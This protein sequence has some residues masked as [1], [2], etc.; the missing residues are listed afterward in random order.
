[1]VGSKTE[2][3]LVGQRA[4]LKPTRYTGAYAI[5][6]RHNPYFKGNCSFQEKWGHCTAHKKLISKNRWHHFDDNHVSSK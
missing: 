4:V 6:R 1:M 3:A 2:T 5:A